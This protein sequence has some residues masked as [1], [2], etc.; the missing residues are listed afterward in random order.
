MALQ[1]FVGTWPLFY[2]PNPSARRKTA[3]YTQNNTN[4]EQTHADIHAL[5]GIRTHDPSVRAG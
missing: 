1:P 4:I 5:I 3:T 2:F